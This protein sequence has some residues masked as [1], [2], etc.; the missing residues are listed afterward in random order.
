MKTRSTFKKLAII[1]LLGM[2]FP[3]AWAQT[4]QERNVGEFTGIKTGGIF[5]IIVSPGTASSVKVEAE[6]A[7]INNIV[8]E[9]KGG[10]LVIS[11]E[12]KV[13]SDK[14]LNIYVTVRELKKVDISGAAKLTGEG[15][16]F[17]AESMQINVAGAGQVKLAVNVANEVKVDVS[18]A[19]TLKLS[20]QAG[21]IKTEASGA[22][23]VKAYDL[24][25]KS[26]SV[27]ASGAANVQV[28]AKEFILA[29]ASGASSVKYKGQPVAKSINKSGSGSVRSADAGT[30]E[31]RTGSGD[32]TKVKV[33]DSSVLII[34]G[35]DE[36]DN[37]RKDKKKKK[38][39]SD[40]EFKHWKGID[41]GVN[42]FLNAD[43]KLG[44][45]E[46]FRFLE[47]DYA[48]SVTWSYNFM[49][50]DIHIYKNYVNLVTGLGFQFDQYG[51][52]NNITLNPD[53]SYISAS[54]D[55]VDYS[56]NRLRTSWINLPLLIDFNLG[57]DPDKAFHIAGGM[58]F[59]YRM[60]A[61]TKQEFS[62]DKREY[63]IT[64]KDDYN[65]APFRYS[66]TVRAGYGD[67]T[68]FAN[69][70][71]ST[72]FENSKGP[73]LYPFSMGIALNFD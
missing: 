58:V 30:D 34:K 26:A 19:G 60:H 4:T 54:Y 24:D 71:L 15:G 45:S 50:K 70:A 69:Y 29:E 7:V 55:S 12:G 37:D 33:G 6:E 44:L 22:A 1:A 8:T 43:N 40:N 23:N 18:G 61:K 42:G 47:L 38:S 66:A 65:L 14:P 67:F 51:F 21:M 20:G 53:A 5:T 63:E 59:G 48:R 39:K 68:I 31:A 25:T 16:E 35:E 28:S 49:E 52:R 62:I 72:L 41:I 3:G 56:V 64:T 36:E 2:I 9:V 73:K 10:D 57:K 32:T 17:T 13:N 46:S 11:T 27:H